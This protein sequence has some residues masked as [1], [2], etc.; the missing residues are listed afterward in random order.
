MNANL[1]KLQKQLEDKAVPSMLISEITNVQWLTGFTGSSGFAVITPNDAVF[2]TDAR[3]DV[4]AKEEVRGMPVAI[5]GSPTDPATFIAESV[6]KMNVGELGFEAKNVTYDTF[7]QWKEKM[8]GV[9]LVGRKDLIEP[10]RMIKDQSELEI[11]K[12][13]CALADKCFENVRRLIQPGVSEYDI[14][15]DIEF[16]FRRQGAEI[17]FAPVVVSG[18]RSARP[19]GRA[20]DKKL[21]AGDFVTLDFGAKVNGY[22][23]DITRTVVVSHASD[24][25]REVYNAVL[26]AQMAAL[27]MMKPGVLARDVDKRSRDVLQERDLAQYF[28]HSLGHGLGRSVHDIGALSAR[29]EIVLEAGQVW[30]VEPGVYIEGFGGVRIED[31]VVVTDS[32][33]ELLTH[34]PKDLLILP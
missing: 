31:D 33:I 24:R 5:Y 17:A 9:Q 27:E 28:G 4:Q 25:H 26:A 10:L 30:T 18:H 34:S 13:A 20:S 2:I 7:S 16:F 32:G 15:L 14:S 29:S 23:S 22:N 6:R 8:D 11:M 3:Y 12:E 21:E 19:H 1:E